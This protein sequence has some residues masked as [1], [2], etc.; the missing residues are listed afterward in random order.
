MFCQLKALLWDLLPLVAILLANWQHSLS[1]LLPVGSIFAYL[2]HLLECFCLWAA[3]LFLSFAFMSICFVFF[4]FRCF[5]SW[6]AFVSFLLPIG[7]IS[8]LVLLPKCSICLGVFVYGSLCFSFVLLIDSIFVSVLFLYAV[9]LSMG[10][11]CFFCQQA[12][13]LFRF[14]C[15]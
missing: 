14:F 1:V 5:S 11:I 2:Q 4:A 13:I 12:A 6:A 7:S 10:D 8:V 3:F 15:L 9:F